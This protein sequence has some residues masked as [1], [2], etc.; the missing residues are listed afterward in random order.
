MKQFVFVVILILCFV[1][2]F[3]LYKYLSVFNDAVSSDIQN[4]GLFSQIFNGVV[5]ALLTSINIWFFYKISIA[6][7]NNNKERSVEQRL[8]EAQK[9][10]TD[11]RVRQYEELSR[12]ANQFKMSI[13]KGQENPQLLEQLKC[14]LRLM[15]DSWLYIY[16]KINKPS[17]IHGE[18]KE[19]FEG[20]NSMS[21]KDKILQITYILT[22]VEFYIILQINRSKG[23]QKYIADPKNEDYIDSTLFY[24]N[25]FLERE[26]EQQGNKP[27]KR[28]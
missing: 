28:N 5:I 3:F 27:S 8:F 24:I 2:I 23:V 13:I 19:F 14:Q 20:Y 10:L 16:D 26:I 9:I 21:P 4:W 18:I 17:Y 25:Q 7:D 12:I 15:D 22:I 1:E 11:M 6:I